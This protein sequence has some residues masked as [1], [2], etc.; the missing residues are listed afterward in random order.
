MIELKVFYKIIITYFH[1]SVKI[2][3]PLSFPIIATISMTDLVQLI[4]TVFQSYK[5]LCLYCAPAR[6][7]ISYMIYVMYRLQ[8]V[9][10]ANAKK[11]A[12]CY[13]EAVL[14]SMVLEYEYTS[15]TIATKQL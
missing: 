6:Y 11:L 9:L 10:W 5:Q 8:R 12:M 1:W 13:S 15:D 14:K 7:V 4:K 3:N 2:V